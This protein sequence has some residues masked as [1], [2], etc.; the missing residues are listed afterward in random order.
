VDYSP[1]ALSDEIHHLPGLNEP[2]AFRQFAGFLKI[3]DTKHIFYWSVSIFPCTNVT[4]A[5]APLPLEER[6]YGTPS[7]LLVALAGWWY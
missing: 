5:T 1:D 6:S 7:L 3:T 2:I 4:P